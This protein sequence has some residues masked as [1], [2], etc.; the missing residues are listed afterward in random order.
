MRKRCLLCPRVA[1]RG[2]S[3]KEN[4]S[5]SFIVAYMV[6]AAP[7]EFFPRQQEASGVTR[8]TCEAAWH[9]TACLLSARCAT[10]GRGDDKK[11]VKLNR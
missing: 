8:I 9:Y 3:F 4:G 5:R 2:A 10:R 7:A 6:S 11:A 1:Q